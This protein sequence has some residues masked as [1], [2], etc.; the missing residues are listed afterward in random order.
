MTRSE[1]QQRIEVYLPADA[2]GHLDAM[3]RDRGRSW[4]EVLAQLIRAEPP[5]ETAPAT[6]AADAMPTNLPVDDVRP[7][8]SGVVPPEAGADA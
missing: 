8:R 4:A 3:A 6:A 1:R 7:I 5:A 2:A